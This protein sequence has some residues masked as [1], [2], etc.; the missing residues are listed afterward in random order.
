MPACQEDTTWQSIII[1]SPI[2]PGIS[3]VICSRRV[4]H[5]SHS[6]FSMKRKSQYSQ[7]IINEFQSAGN[8]K[9]SSM[10]HWKHFSFTRTHSACKLPYNPLS[11]TQIS[12]WNSTKAVPLSRLPPV[13]FYFQIW[14]S[15][16]DYTLMNMIIKIMWRLI[17][18]NK[19]PSIR[20][21]MAR[22]KDI[23]CKSAQG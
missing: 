3:S 7:N 15:D 5:K 12:Q 1:I 14:P 9:T 16:N 6:D 18:S 8:M 22:V 19:S 13:S 2:R 4:K 20:N 11:A 17:V 21:A 23:P 10:L